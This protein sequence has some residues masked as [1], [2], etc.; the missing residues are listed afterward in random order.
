MVANSFPL[1]LIS[2]ACFRGAPGADGRECWVHGRK[3]KEQQHSWCTAWSAAVLHLCH[4]SVGFLLDWLPPLLSEVILF[5]CFSV[6]YLS[7]PPI[8]S[9]DR[10]FLLFTSMSLEP[11]PQHDTSRGSGACC[12][13]S[14]TQ[15][16]L[17]WWL[18]PALS[19]RL[20][21]KARDRVW[22]VLV[23]ITHNPDWHIKCV[24]KPGTSGSCL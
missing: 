3:C 16:T 22:F 20:R 2:C 15:C 23:F 13:S 7:L 10:N 14:V 19:S 5:I 6:Y 9:E 21:L 4:P 1:Q 18:N 8:M 24:W 17:L 11:S 12:H